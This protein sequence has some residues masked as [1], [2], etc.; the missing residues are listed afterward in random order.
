MHISEHMKE[1]WKAIDF[2]PAGF[3]LPAMEV[4]DQ[5]KTLG[6]D[7]DILE[8]ETFEKTVERPK[9]QEKD[10][11]KYEGISISNFPP[12]LT[13]AEVLTFLL[14]K[15]LPND[16]DKSIVQLT[17]TDKT[18]KVIINES[19]KPETVQ[20]LLK[21]IHFHETSEKFWNVPL[22]CKA[23][24]SLTPVKVV[25]A[26]ELPQ[27]ELVVTEQ[28]TARTTPNNEDEVKV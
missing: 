25:A 1:L 27:E 16:I 12:N 8:T 4:E 13:E 10:I 26:P 6:G 24:R 28:V 3:E 23:I 17:R 15:G 11:E 9:P 18:I 5:E 7:V 2:V 19:L 21:N 22:F 14:E 20:D